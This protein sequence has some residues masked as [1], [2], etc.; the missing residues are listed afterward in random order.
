MNQ[1]TDSPSPQTTDPRPMR[2]YPCPHCGGR[3]EVILDNDFEGWPIWRR[4]GYCEGRGHFTRPVL[5]RGAVRAFRVTLWPKAL[6]EPVELITDATTAG[7]AKMD[8]L[9]DVATM[10]GCS[11]GEAIRTMHPTV[12]RAPE[13]DGVRP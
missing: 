8:C 5:P 9:R 1:S 12:R 7:A 3:G 11:I 13:H 4:C 6:D 2:D 10:A